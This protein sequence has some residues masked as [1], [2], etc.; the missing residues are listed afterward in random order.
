MI[1]P[2]ENGAAFD[3]VVQTL[4]RGGVAII[5]CDTMYGIVGAAPDTEQRIRR[6]KGRGETKPFL[7]LIAR[8]SWIAE[9]S[10]QPLPPVFSRYWPGPLTLVF[11]A[12]AGGTV[13]LRLPDSP[14]LRRLMETVGRPFYSTSVNRAGEDPIFDITRIKAEF[15]PDVDLILDAGNLPPGPPSTLVDIT[16]RPYKILR[17]GAVAIP[18]EDLA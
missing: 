18:P 17:T 14:F 5:P 2:A 11:P 16:R 9:L 13:A 1:V 7:Q 8:A 3:S 12:R 6:V 15:E 10:D 4:A